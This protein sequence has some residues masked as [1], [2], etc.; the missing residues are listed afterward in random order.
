MRK[1]YAII[2]LLLAIL[3][4]IRANAYDFS[5][6]C[7]TGQTLYYNI[8]S[9]EGSYTV[10]VTAENETSPYYTIYPSGN[11]EIPASVEYNGI[12]YSVTSV[13]NNSF[14]SCYELTSV[15]IPNSVTSIGTYAFYYCEAL[16]S[17]S[18]PN[19]LTE[20]GDNAFFYCT[21]LT[22][23]TIP[24]SVISIGDRAFYGE[25]LTTVNFNATNCTYM[26]SESENVFKNCSALTTLNIGGNVV[27]IPDYAFAQCYWLTTVTIPS[28]VAVIGT[29]AFKGVKNIVYEGSA[30]G[31]PWG[32]LTAN[33]Y[34][35]GSLVYFDD[36]KTKI[37]GC[38]A[39]ATSVE[40]PGTVTEIGECAFYECNSLTTITIPNGITSIGDHAFFCQNLTTF[41]FNATNCTYMGSDIN[42]RAIYLCSSLSTLNIGDN[43]TNIPNY[44]FAYCGNLTSFTMGN[45]VA[46]VGEYAFYSCS[47]SEITVPESVTNIG[48]YAFYSDNITTVNFNAIN[49]ST[50]NSNSSTRIFSQSLTN[51]NIGG[52]VKS[53]P[54]YTFYYCR[55]LTEV[56]IPDSVEYIGLSAF[57]NCS[58]LTT[59]Y[60]NAENCTTMGY[61]FDY[62]FMGC[63]LLTTVIFGDNVKS[64][65]A[66]AFDEQA[67]LTTVIFGSSLRTIGDFAF[68]ECT[69]IT[70]ITLPNS[71]T[72]VGYRAF[73]GC[74]GVITLTIGNSL[75]EFDVGSFY[76]VNQGT[77]EIRVNDGNPTY[78]SRGNCNAIIETATNTLIMGCQNTVIPDDVTKIGEDAFGYCLG[79]TE[80]TIPNSVTEI[81]YYAFAHCYNITEITIPNSVTYISTLA[82]YYCTGLT[83][84]NF[85]AIN[86]TYM[87]E[88][89]SEVFGHCSSLSALNIGEGVT[90]IPEYGFAATSISN[91]NTSAYVPPTIGSTTF[92]SE[93]F[94]TADIYAPCGAVPDYRSASQ[95]NNF[96]SI[97][98]EPTANFS[99]TVQTENETMG[100]VTG[101]GTF[102][103]EE[104]LTITATAADGYR[105]LEWSDGNT[106]TPRTI[107]VWG[108]STLVASFRAIHTITASAGDNG[109]I[110]PSGEI[111]V[112][113]AADQSF[114]ITPDT[115]YRIA[116]VIVDGQTDVTA[117]LVDGVYTFANVTEDHTISATFEN[118]PYTIEVATNNDEYG[119]VSGGGTYD[120]GSEI[121]LTATP[122]ENCHFVSWNDGNTDN[123][124][125]F[126]VTGD[127]TFVATF[128]RNLCTITVLASDSDFGSVTGGGQYAIGDT[129]VL[130]ATPNIGYCF[131]SWDDDSLANPRSFVA[132]GDST[133]VADFSSAA[134]RA[135]DTTV[136]SYLTLDE[137]TFY[138]SGVYS[139]VIPSDLGCDTI[140]DLTLQ[141][142]DEP[143]AFDIS[144][145]PAKSIISISSENYISLVEIYST[146]GM[147]AMQKE[148]NAN[149]AEVNVEWLVSGVYF[150]RLFGE[151]GGQPSVQRFVKE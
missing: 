45:S 135:V 149:R 76:Y 108:D 113:E 68:H 4:A 2:F 57:R 43:V 9:N 32:A 151:D 21:N 1:L 12:T 116:S 144:P 22:S 90:N 119:T 54:N 55:G 142:L 104:E 39:S 19:S 27:N 146:T 84:V 42:N 134:H 105:F 121:T 148:I 150:V 106:E 28:T 5:A 99:I 132:A 37:T 61:S 79:L 71:V 123:P 15:T 110:T 69:G 72:S 88:S 60:Y 47:I 10:E 25:N 46:N 38:I 83:T 112:D 24:E 100:S 17:V 33:G 51:L 23:V 87:G 114:T 80:I 65:P 141:V 137:H 6:A 126:I 91:I 66:M 143:E 63:D 145:N 62:A 3:F 36:T 81:G 89:G 138:A 20:I 77:T 125:T 41:N 103:C 59:V 75:T 44:A 107:V 7:S 53:I 30:T 52:N 120:A 131:I 92:S 94:S 11:L 18:L 85:N 40:I 34:V 133:F 98:G 93:T 118:I 82:F 136:T 124:R 78:D 97:Q 16:P 74:S 127:S 29:D 129:V 101:G 70:E 130:T 58:N 49:S 14:R 50:T 139:Y 96:T 111:V 140:V 86:C 8:T 147:L 67:S 95:W 48:N 26:G 115:Y 64:I 35:E 13:G 56:T 128:E 109:T 73:W 117:Q 102:S 31:S 122:N